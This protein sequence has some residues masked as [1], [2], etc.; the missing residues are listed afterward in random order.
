MMVV[1]IYET[2]IYDQGKLMS[3]LALKYVCVLCVSFS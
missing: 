2:N 3:C 1:D